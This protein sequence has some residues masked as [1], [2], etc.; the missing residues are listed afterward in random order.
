MDIQ[1]CIK[2]ATE[3]PICFIATT[4]GDQPRVRTLALE[5]ANE[6]GFYFAILSPKQFYRQLKANP[7]VEVCFYNNPSDLM[8][9]KQMRVTGK[10]EPVY[11]Q[12]LQER[13]AGEGAFLEELTGKQ[14]GHLWKV[15]RIHSGEAFFWTL[16]DTL[17]EPELERIGF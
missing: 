3:N 16:T 15:F 7:K 14:L 4:D 13:V 6:T 9:A 8:Q 17:M 5:F 11:D 10:M 2:F 1:D 12:E